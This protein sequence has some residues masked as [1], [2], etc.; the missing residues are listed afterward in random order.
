ME[1]E[2]FRTK[3][4]RGKRGQFKVRNAFTIYQIYKF[5]RKHGWYNIGRPVTEK[6]F[7]SI[8]RNVNKGFAENIANGED[9][10][11]PANM[12]KL[13]LRKFE[14]KVGIDKNGKLRIGYPVDWD[15]TLRLWY[16][17][18]E[19]YDNKTVVRDE[20]KF[21]YKLMYNK[22]KANYENMVFYD[23]KPH[24]KVRVALK[25]NIKNGKTD[26]LW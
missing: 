22:Y 14:R 16:E 6:E 25:E 5:I 8:I 17:D 3:I 21:T 9:I 2:E 11:F 19:A 24:K 15:K 4:A 7:Y 18:K 20:S 1:F 12:G 10:V 26:S 23:F 13:E